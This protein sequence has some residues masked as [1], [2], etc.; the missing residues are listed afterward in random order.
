[1]PAA[2]AVILGVDIHKVLH[3]AVA[4]DKLGRRLGVTS[5]PTDDAHQV[6]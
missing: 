5:V 4:L 3:V 2:T 1:V 6:F